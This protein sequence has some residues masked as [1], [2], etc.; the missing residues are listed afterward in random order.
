MTLLETT[1]ISQS[2]D[3][4]EYR[5]PMASGVRV[6]MVWTRSSE[7]RIVAYSEEFVAGQRLGESG[8][9][10]KTPLSLF[11]SEIEFYVTD[12]RQRQGASGRSTPVPQTLCPHG[13]PTNQKC[14]SC[15]YEA[16]CD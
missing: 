15:R 4:V 10:F 14:G 9:V 3:G 7:A 12:A 6:V 11:E 16:G 8:I 5:T 1:R 2:P 13:I